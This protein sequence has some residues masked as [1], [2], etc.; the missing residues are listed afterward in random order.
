MEKGRGPPSLA[1]AMRPL[2]IVPSSGGHTVTLTALRVPR[3]RT[4]IGRDLD[5]PQGMTVEGS[6]SLPLRGQSPVTHRL[7]GLG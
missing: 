7:G 4:R 2:G 3:G 6:G 5:T 1:L